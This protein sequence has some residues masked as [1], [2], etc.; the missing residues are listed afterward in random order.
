M[1]LKN[2]ALVGALAL[3]FGNAQ[4]TLF[5]RGSGLIYDDVLKVTWLQDANYAKTSGYDTDGKMNW[6][7]ALTWADGLSYG[8]YSDWRLAA[9][10][11]VGSDWNY[12]FAYNGTT[13]EGYNI[14]S[15][16]SELSYMYYVNLGLKGYVD[17]SGV[18]QP[19]FG[20]Y[21]DGTT[22]G[23]K[24]VGPVNNLQANPYW[25]GTANTRYPAWQ[26][27]IH[28]AWYFHNGSGFQDGL[29]QPFEFYA[30]AVRDGDVASVA[31]PIPEPE[32]YAMLLAGLG[33]LGV[34][35]KRRAKL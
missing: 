32:T 17:T 26:N 2:I 21:G 23:Q 11:S 10:T 7:A 15:S 9:N 12:E 5:D 31:A 6:S 27:P 14:T 30:W 4:A 13:D 25:S 28:L 35:A 29:H 1:R 19:A 34:M 22:G 33:L 16:H 3:A 24:D 8:G 20:V 18:Y